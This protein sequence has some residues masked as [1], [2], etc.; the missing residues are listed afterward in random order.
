[1]IDPSEGDLAERFQTIDAELRAYGEGLASRAQLV[2]LN[3]ADLGVDA[4]F[5]TSDQRVVGVIKTSA[6]TGAGIEQLKDAV[7]SLVPDEVY[8]PDEVEL[9][10]YLVYRPQAPHRRPFRV[11]RTDTGWLVTGPRLGEVNDEEIETALRQAGA[12]D[13][14]EVTI[15][16]QTHELA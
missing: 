9:A 7:F 16:A 1:V 12:N 11:L 10:D 6:V 4:T 3:K 13:G 15:G 5:E 2:V 14:D 8:V